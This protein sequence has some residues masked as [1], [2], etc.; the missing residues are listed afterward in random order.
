MQ[1]Q[2]A[3]VAFFLLCSAGLIGTAL[4]RHEQ[5]RLTTSEQFGW[6][7]ILLGLVQPVAAWLLFFYVLP[8][9]I[10]SFA[11]FELL[12]ALCL[13][14][15]VAQ[16]PV[17]ARQ[18]ILLSVCAAVV[19]AIAAQ[20][21][22]AAAPAINGAV[23]I[24]AMLGASYLCIAIEASKT[25]K[26]SVESSKSL[27]TLSVIST[28]ATVLLLS[29]VVLLAAPLGAAMPRQWLLE[30]VGVIWLG[31]KLLITAE[32]GHLFVARRTEGADRL[33]RALVQ[34]ANALQNGLGIA[35]QAL[36]QS[37]GMVLIARSDGKL[38]FAN[39]GAR[40]FLAFP[41]LDEQ[42]LEALF[43]TVQPGPH[44]KLRAVFQRPDQHVAIL[45]ISTML[46]EFQTERL[47]YMMLEPLP[48]DFGDLRELLNEARADAA[49]EITGLLDQ[50][51]AIISMSDAWATLLGPMDRY[52]NSGLLW[53]KLRILSDNDT[54]IAQLENAILATNKATAWLMRRSDGGISVAL[55]K[56]YTPDHRHFFLVRVTLI[57]EARLARASAPL[58]PAALKERAAA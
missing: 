38:V 32:L 7:A 44:G 5:T 41:E 16:P 42:T 31:L 2:A 57:D 40:K 55:E 36:Y 17:P 43:L 23:I 34:Q 30:A 1:F 48:F 37:P 54:E 6:M 51:F 15:S 19:L 9:D 45:Q 27:A 13:A 52:A 46:L 35:S 39:A 26:T 10:N 3:I 29:T 47:H 50:H 58:A 20:V 49:Y 4:L 18:H 25:A 56:L 14:G 8:A 53:D 21:A 22:P 24:V 11:G 12:S 33:S 28:L